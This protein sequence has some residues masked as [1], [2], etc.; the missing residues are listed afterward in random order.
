[1]DAFPARLLQTQT[2]VLDGQG[3]EVSAVG[4][5]LLRFE[6]NSDLTALAA[7][8]GGFL[9]QSAQTCDSKLT[10]D[11]WPYVFDSEQDS[12]TAL[13][14]FKAATG[15]AYNLATR[16]E[17]ICIRV[18]IGGTMNP[19]ASS[20][21]KTIRYALSDALREELRAY[22]AQGGL[23]DLQLSQNCREHMCRPTSNTR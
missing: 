5:L 20:R 13:V 22:E 3:N 8:R 7:S 23:A 6:S 15:V 19:L 18:G 9:W 2:A 16:P 21:S 12:Y 14:A 4:Y 17:D 11:G 10:L 1:M